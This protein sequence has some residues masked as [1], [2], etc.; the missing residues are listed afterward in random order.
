[1]TLSQLLTGLQ[2]WVLLDEMSINL[3]LHLLYVFKSFTIDVL[4]NGTIL[5]MSCWTQGI[6]EQQRPKFSPYALFHSHDALI[7]SMAIQMPNTASH[8]MM[9]PFPFYLNV[10]NFVVCCRIWKLWLSNIHI[11]KRNIPSTFPIMLWD[12]LKEIKLWR[13]VFLF[14]GN[15]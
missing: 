1:M 14:S 3:P 6:S 9:E 12:C 4:A 2:T 8:L 10:Q 13:Q 7:I 15:F 5:L 11:R